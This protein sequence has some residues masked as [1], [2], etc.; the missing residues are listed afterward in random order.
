MPL[1][2]KNDCLKLNSRSKAFIRIKYSE[3]CLNRII[4]SIKNKELS[5]P[6]KTGLLSDTLSFMKSGTVTHD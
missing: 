3:E 2:N 4:R 6:D 5:T 1:N